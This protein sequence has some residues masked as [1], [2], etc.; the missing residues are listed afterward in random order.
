LADVANNRRARPFNSG[1]V[2]Q[3]SNRGLTVSDIDHDRIDEA[4]LALLFLGRHDE[5]RTWKSFDWATME[6]LH[7]KGYISNP[8]GKAKSVVFSEEGLQKS[9]ALFRKLFQ[10]REA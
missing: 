2:G 1:I 10:K 4:V 6:R 5:F 8:I 9:E 3:P 7:A